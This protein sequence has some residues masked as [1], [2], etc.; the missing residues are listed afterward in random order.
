MSIYY[1]SSLKLYKPN[2][3]KVTLKKKKT[4]F[5]PTFGYVKS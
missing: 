5:T 3:E 2:T 1:F 4:M